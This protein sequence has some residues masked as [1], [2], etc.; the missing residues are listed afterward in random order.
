MLSFTKKSNAIS[1]GIA[2]KCPSCGAPINVN[3]SGKCEY[4]GSIYN[5]YDYDWIL[6][7]L[8]IC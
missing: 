5:Q 7:K 2:K 3:L 8:R 1:Q 4:C 6:S